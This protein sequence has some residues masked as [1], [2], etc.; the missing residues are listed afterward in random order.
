MKLKNY[1]YLNTVEHFGDI[2]KGDTGNKGYKGFQGDAGSTGLK[3]LTGAVGQE[4][5][6]IHD[7]CI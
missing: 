2:I 6:R 7:Q 1:Y 3:G 4:A 5:D